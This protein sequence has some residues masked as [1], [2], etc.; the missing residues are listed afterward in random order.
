MN[1]AGRTESAAAD[2]SGNAMTAT[3]TTARTAEK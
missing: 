3:A 2:V 1:L